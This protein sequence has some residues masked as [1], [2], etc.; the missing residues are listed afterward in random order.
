MRP[1]HRRR[2]VPN[3][4]GA[5]RASLP[6]QQVRVIVPYPA[7][8]PTMAAPSSRFPSASA[9]LLR[10]IYRRERRRRQARP[11]IPATDIRPVTNDFAISTRYR[12]VRTSKSRP[13]STP[14]PRQW[15]LPSFSK[16]MQAHRA[17]KAEP[18]NTNALARPVRQL[19]ANGC[20][21]WGSISTS[22][23]AVPGAAP[24]TSHWRTRR[25]RSAC[26]RR[27]HQGRQLR[28]LAV[29]SP[30]A[31]R[32]QGSDRPGRGQREV[33]LIISVVARRDPKT[34]RRPV[35]AA[36]RR[37]VAC[38]VKRVS[39]RSTLRRSQRLACAAESGGLR[40]L[41]QVVR[42]ANIKVE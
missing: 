2:G 1:D 23:S 19:S 4:P 32:S 6:T 12:A 41:E 36:D 26:R 38:R 28:A 22:S 13:V 29:T 35:A 5:P 25:S 42:D 14:R 21:A 18:V 31:R 34:N 11:P 16:T 15:C 17:A 39:T 3:A 20:F 9:E 37:I 24:I 8:G 10:Q 40:D 7:G 33:E 30:N 27:C